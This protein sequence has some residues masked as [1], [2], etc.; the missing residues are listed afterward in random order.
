MVARA[1]FTG[2]ALVAFA[3]QAQVEKVFNA[4]GFADF[5]AVEGKAVWAT[6]RGHIERWTLKGKVAEVPMAK[7]CGAMAVVRHA[8]WVA[9]CQERTIS[10]IDTRSGK[11]TATVATGIASTNGEL[12]VVAGAGSIW[13]ASDAKGVVARVDPISN[14][15]TASITVDPDTYYLA[16]AFGSI[17]AVSD[18]RQTIQRIDPRTNMVIKRTALGRQSSFLAAGA[19][20]IWV[21]EQGDGSVARVDAV[22]GDVT[23]RVKVGES[24]KFSDIDT[25]GGKVWVRTKYEQLF[26]V[27]DPKSLAITARVGTVQGSGG[28]RYT[29]R[30]LWTTQHDRQTLSWWPDP[31][32][33]GK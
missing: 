27:I 13:V 6:N 31:A 12:A 14:R 19:D 20:A 30:G 9:D 22:S 32:R 2:C 5:L 4:P 33:I 23:G 25:G 3:A 8:I 29:P 17:W 24:L 28:L 18:S 26:V 1:A 21:V 11:I 16:Y 7:P 15:V 10:R